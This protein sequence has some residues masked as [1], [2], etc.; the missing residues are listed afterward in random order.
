MTSHSWCCT[1]NKYCRIFYTFIPRLSLP[2]QGL[3]F[4]LENGSRSRQMLDAYYMWIRPGQDNE[5]RLF[6]SS[7]G[8]KVRSAG[9][10]VTRLHAHY[11]LPDIKSQEIRRTV[12]TDAAANFTEEQKASVAHYMAHSTAVANQHYRMK[13]LDTVVATANLLSSLTR[14][15]PPVCQC[16]TW[17]FPCECH[18]SLETAGRWIRHS[19]KNFNVQPRHC[20]V[21][22]PEGDRHVLLFQATKDIVNDEEIR[23]DH[24]VKRRSF[25]GEEEELKWLDV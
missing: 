6:L 13:T 17:N 19:K 4:F 8:T 3:L 7:A 21:T 24:G 9:N 2:F 14:A 10:D 18:P 11:K 15:H 23:F 12:E 20:T 5:D 1:D 22:L 25:R 16:V